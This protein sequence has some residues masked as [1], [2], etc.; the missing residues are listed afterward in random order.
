[1]ADLDKVYQGRCANTDALMA[2]LYIEH[3][4]KCGACGVPLAFSERK[5]AWGLDHVVPVYKGGL[6]TRSNLM[7]L[8]RACHRAKTRPEIQEIRK[9]FPNTSKRFWQ[10]H[11]EKDAKIAALEREIAEL[12]SAL[13]ATR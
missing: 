8:C 9:L 6:T 13:E 2:L 12:R 10:T 3:G 4:R 7:P 5:R 11:S 1:M